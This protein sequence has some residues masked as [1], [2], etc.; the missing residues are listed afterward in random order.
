MVKASEMSRA[1]GCIMPIMQ[2]AISRMMD[3]DPIPM[4]VFDD[5]WSSM[6]E[7]MQGRKQMDPQVSF[8]SVTCQHCELDE[9]FF[10]RRNDNVVVMQMSD[11]NAGRY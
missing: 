11:M 4:G 1:Y 2:V 9:R 10:F 6:V 5:S 3:P 8:M 7:M